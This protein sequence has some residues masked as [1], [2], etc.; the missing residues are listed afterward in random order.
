VRK[1]GCCRLDFKSFQWEGQELEQQL[2]GEQWGGHKVPWSGW[3][4][5]GPCY[6]SAGP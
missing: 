5:V 6:T 4:R 3:K 2:G 1:V